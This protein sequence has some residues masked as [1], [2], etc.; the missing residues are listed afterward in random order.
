MHKCSRCRKEYDYKLVKK[1]AWSSRYC[2]TNCF[3][4][5]KPSFKVGDIVTVIK[6]PE[7]FENFDIV[8][9]DGD[10]IEYKN[11]P[12]LNLNFFVIKE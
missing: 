6:C 9:E 1:Y 10:I 11:D 12:K 2:S 5:L 7:E 3:L 8:G 4:N